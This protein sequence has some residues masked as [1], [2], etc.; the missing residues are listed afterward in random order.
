MTKRKRK[1]ERSRRNKT[2]RSLPTELRREDVARIVYEDEQRRVLELSPAMQDL[3]Q[4]QLE[5]FRKKFGREPGPDD[6]IFFDPDADEPRPLPEGYFSNMMA[7]VART[8]G[9]SEA[10]AYAI[11][12]TGM[13]IVDGLNDHLFSEDDKAAWE[14]AINEF[15]AMS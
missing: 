1:P 4:V 12:K 10:K 6:P 2:R 9:I 3:L 14:A 5:Q 15:E 7:E 8:A 11:R 13:M